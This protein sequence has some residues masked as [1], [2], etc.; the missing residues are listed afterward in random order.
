MTSELAE[1]NGDSASLTELAE[2]INAHHAEFATA[3]QGAAF[4]ALEIGRLLIEAQSQ[5]ERGAW[6]PWVEANCAFDVRQSQKYVRFYLKQYQTRIPNSRFNL[7]ETLAA[8]ASPGGEDE[9][10]PPE[11]P[12]EEGDG[13]DEPE[14]A[15][16]PARWTASEKKRKRTVESGYSVVANMKTD[17]RLIDWAKENDLFV[18]IDRKTIWGNPF[19]L[20]ADGDRATVLDHYTVYLTMKPSLQDR[21]DELR[22]KVLGCWCYPDECHADIL[23]RN[24]HGECAPDEAQRVGCHS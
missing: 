22:G 2:Q 15:A 24:A 10:G 16:K 23:I 11:L 8:L 17:I 20:N 7:D 14:P 18:K 21:F 1:V 13:E 4:K 12:P 6:V 5:V 3:I 19:I 9:P